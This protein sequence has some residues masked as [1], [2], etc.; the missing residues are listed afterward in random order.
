MIKYHYI[1]KETRV[2]ESGGRE[3]M[4]H[5]MTMLLRRVVGDES[6]PS[7]PPTTGAARLHL[8]LGMIEGERRHGDEA[9]SIASE[10]T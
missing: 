6:H 5:H 9:T 8:R 10:Y 3:P 7:S 2:R 4:T 1:P